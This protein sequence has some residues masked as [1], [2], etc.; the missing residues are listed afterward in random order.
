MKKKQDKNKYFSKNRIKQYLIFLCVTIATYLLITPDT[1]STTFIS[2]ILFGIAT[3]LSLAFFFSMIISRDKSYI[4]T[5]QNQSKEDIS[6]PLKKLETSVKRLSK[7]VDSTKSLITKH[8]ATTSAFQS[9]PI[10]FSIIPSSSS[11]EAY[12]L[13][14]DLKIPFHSQQEK[15]LYDKL[16]HLLKKNG[17]HIRI[18]K[19]YNPSFS[20]DACFD[21]E[22]QAELTYNSIGSDF[23]Q[24]LINFN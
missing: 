1:F 13:D 15:S 18:L 14:K 12:I 11:D 22:S 3:G 20:S 19:P 9:M 17:H 5:L 7:S 16:V 21:K 10:N 6:T 23:P 2:I 24:N 4:Q 8:H